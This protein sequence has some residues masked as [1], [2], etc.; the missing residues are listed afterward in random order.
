MWDDADPAPCAYFGVMHYFRRTIETRDAQLEDC[1]IYAVRAVP[2]EERTDPVRVV[3]GFPIHW[4]PTENPGQL[5]WDPASTERYWLCEVP[6]NQ[7]RHYQEIS[8]DD[9][10]AAYPGLPSQPASHRHQSAT[11]Q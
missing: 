6:R 8:R 7:F 9:A 4:R 1:V 10:L 11:S 2:P 5:F 3:A